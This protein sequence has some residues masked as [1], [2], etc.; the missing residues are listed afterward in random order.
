MNTEWI[1]ARWLP[2]LRGGGY[3]QGTGALRQYDAY[4]C[5]GVACDLL[6]QDGIITTPWNTDPAYDSKY[7]RVGA[8]DHVENLPQEAATFLGI[9][10]TGLRVQNPSTGDHSSLMV[11][12]D[13]WK[14]DFIQIADA[15]ERALDQGEPTT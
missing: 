14:L 15:I 1:R 2:A 7:Y 8:D 6:L 11:A 5:L 4:C 3:E 13:G 9:P 10:H 12:N